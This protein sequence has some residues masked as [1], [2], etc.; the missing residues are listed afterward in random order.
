MSDYLLT[1]ITS[2]ALLMALLVYL[3]FFQGAANRY[4][5]S[6]VGLMGSSLFHVG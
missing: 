5:L 3:N 2:A 4:L 1:Q 6:Q